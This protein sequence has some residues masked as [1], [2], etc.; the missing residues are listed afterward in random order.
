MGG[1]T[2]SL[3]RT[4]G[5]PDNSRAWAESRLGEDVAKFFCERAR[6]PDFDVRKAELDFIKE[7]ARRGNV[8]FYEDILRW[9]PGDLGDKLQEDFEADMFV[10]VEYDDVDTGLRLWDDSALARCDRCSTSKSGRCRKHE[11]YMQA[12]EAYLLKCETQGP[13]P[14]KSVAEIFAKTGATFGDFEVRGTDEDDVVS[15]RARLRATEYARVAVAGKGI[16]V[17]KCHHRCLREIYCEIA[18]YGYWDDGLRPAGEVELKLPP[19]FDDSELI[20]ASTPLSAILKSTTPDEEVAKRTRGL[21]DALE[22]ARKMFHQKKQETTEMEAKLSEATKEAAHAF[23]VV[24]ELTDAIEEAVKEMGR[25]D[26]QHPSMPEQHCKGICLDCALKQRLKRSVSAVTLQL[27]NSAKHN[28]ELDAALQKQRATTQELQNAHRKTLDAVLKK[29]RETEQELRNARSLHVTEIAKLNAAN[30]KLE[31]EVAALRTSNADLDARAVVF[32]AGK[33]QLDE[34]ER[35]VE[36]VVCKDRHVE[37]VFHCGHT[38]CAP[39]GERLDL[40][41]DPCPTCHQKLGYRKRL[42]LGS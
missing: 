34:L 39:C 19:L 25:H 42:Y 22:I 4:Y 28:K 18:G 13:Q 31:S 17:I 1:M 21:Q 35:L 3:A 5:L 9:G 33:A 40:N 20:A 15:Q 30:A 16:A 12:R 14:M 41:D 7:S 11:Q 37:V 32:N 6:E 36:C 27:A 10:V 26:P 8:V 29:Q 2:S 23:K 38:T 24:D